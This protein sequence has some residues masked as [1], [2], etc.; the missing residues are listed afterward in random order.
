MK[1]LFLLK[2]LSKASEYGVWS[3]KESGAVITSTEQN[4]QMT[5]LEIYTIKLTAKNPKASSTVK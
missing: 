1:M 5:L 2:D 3:S 4:P